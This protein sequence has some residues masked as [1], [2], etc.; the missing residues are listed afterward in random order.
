MKRD[1]DNASPLDKPFQDRPLDLA[2]TASLNDIY[3][4]ADEDVRDIIS[5][6]SWT[7]YEEGYLEGYTGKPS[8]FDHIRTSAQEIWD[9]GLED[10]RGDKYLQEIWS[11][12]FED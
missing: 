8:F 10:G 4:D 9:I 5:G 6:D 7:A 1:V 11:N 2:L 3:A 12:D